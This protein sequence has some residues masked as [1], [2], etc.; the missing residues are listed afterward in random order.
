MP[1]SICQG[2]FLVHFWT[3][4]S[5]C[6]KFKTWLRKNLFIAHLNWFS[7]TY[8]AGPKCLPSL[9]LVSG[10]SIFI[11]P[12]PQ[13]KRE[14]RKLRQYLNAP[15]YQAKCW[16]LPTCLLVWLWESLVF[17]KEPSRPCPGLTQ[18]EEAGIQELPCQTRRSPR[19]RESQEFCWPWLRRE[20]N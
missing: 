13:K 4:W 10:V 1:L 8:G 17:S 3:I 14:R 9:S 15:L 20:G 19:L 11:S 6:E 18:D 12:P 5:V 16:S 7:S 2:M